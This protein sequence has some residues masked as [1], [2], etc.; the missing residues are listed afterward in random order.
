MIENDKQLAITKSR[1]L[2]FEEEIA[3]YK[4]SS[5]KPRFLTDAFIASA[6][7]QLE[8]FKADVAE[9]ESREKA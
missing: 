7:S 9:Y 2:R 4:Q 5:E 6:E 3:N 1:I 8:E